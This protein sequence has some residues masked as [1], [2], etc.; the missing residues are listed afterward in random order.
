MTIYVTALFF[1]FF[2][3]KNNRERKMRKMK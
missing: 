2:I 3:D 1:S